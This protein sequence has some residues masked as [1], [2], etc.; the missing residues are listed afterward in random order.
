MIKSRLIQ[1]IALMLL[2]AGCT[3]GVRT[4][5]VNG[6]MNVD[7]KP[8]GG[9]EIS[10]TN[11][12]TG[13]IALAYAGKDGTFSLSRGRGNKDIPVGIYEVIATPTGEMQDVPHPKVRVQPKDAADPNAP[14]Q[15]T[16]VEG[17]N[18]LDLQFRSIK[19]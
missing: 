7:E 13:A 3:P 15:V 8:L 5:T 2:V 11:K 14:L 9:F 6:T 12:D 10:F 4:G 19:K 1:S 17:S 18:Q 16:V